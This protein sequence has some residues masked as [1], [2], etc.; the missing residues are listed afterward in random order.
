MRSGPRRPQG[1]RPSRPW[2]QYSAPQ[3]RDHRLPSLAVQEAQLGAMRMGYYLYLLF[4]LAIWWFVADLL[5]MEDYLYSLS[6]FAIA[7]FIRDAGDSAANYDPNEP[8]LRCRPPRRPTSS[9]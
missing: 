4:L 2:R 7:W 8:D 5:T 6:T 9:P 1:T 3:V